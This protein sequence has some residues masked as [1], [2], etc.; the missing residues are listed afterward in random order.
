MFTNVKLSSLL[1]LKTY[2]SKIYQ[3]VELIANILIISVA[4][5]VGGTLV[6]RYFF[7]SSVSAPVQQARLQPVVGSKTEVPDVNWSQQP[8]TLVL[9]LQTGCHFCNDSAP[10]YKR[11]IQA[12]ENKNVKLVA[13]FPTDVKESITHLNELGLTNMEV[14]QSPL[15]SLQVSGT[16]TLILTNDKGEITN[17]WVGRLPPDKEAEVLNQLQ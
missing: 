7:S 17:Y 10:F 6:Q 13:V 14:R 12:V 1:N 4:L 3:K 9:V 15:S 8:K 16:P 5:G 11:I 2:M